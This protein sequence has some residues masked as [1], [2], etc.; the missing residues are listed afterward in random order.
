MFPRA[1]DPLRE[2]A[3]QEPGVGPPGEV[4]GGAQEA[5]PVHPSQEAQDRGEEGPREAL[6][7][8]GPPRRRLRS[9]RSRT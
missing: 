1:Q 2:R 9:R 8:Q 4:L 7:V 5:L 6:R 3:H